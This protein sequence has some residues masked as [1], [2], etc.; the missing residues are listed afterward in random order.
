MRYYRYP[1]RRPTHVTLIDPYCCPN[2]FDDPFDGGSSQRFERQEKA[3][4]SE[5]SIA[6]RGNRKSGSF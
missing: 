3:R 6:G 4:N 5:F 1:F 2:I